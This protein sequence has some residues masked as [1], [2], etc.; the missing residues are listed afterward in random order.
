MKS[1]EKYEDLLK[2]IGAESE[3][4]FTYGKKELNAF[5][6]NDGSDEG[7]EPYF[8]F[9]LEFNSITYSIGVT[10]KELEDEEYLYIYWLMDI[11]NLNGRA[12]K[13]VE[14]ILY[15]Y[16]TIDL[17][18]FDSDG[19]IVDFRGIYSDFSIKGTI[20]DSSEKT[21]ITIDNNET[22]YINA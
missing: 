17:V 14:K 9:D 15:K 13:D 7:D 21:T 20:K 22:I 10:H 6:E 8:S 3:S 4:D 16:M 5:L 2:A 11:K 1:F 12:W 18:N 19:G